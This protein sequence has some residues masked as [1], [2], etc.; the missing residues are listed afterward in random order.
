MNNNLFKTLGDIA[1][2]LLITQNTNAPMLLKMFLNNAMGKTA[3]E[4]EEH[5]LSTALMRSLDDMGENFSRTDSGLKHGTGK[6]KTV[7]HIS[8]DII[9][10][11]NKK[12]KK[13]FSLY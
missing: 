3:S 7:I 5:L 13:V 9:N 4:Q 11:S 10:F 8:S 6:K 2:K 12:G 1:S